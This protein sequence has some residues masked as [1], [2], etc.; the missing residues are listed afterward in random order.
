M[1]NVYNKRDKTQAVTSI[2]DY[3]KE[4]RKLLVTSGKS[5]LFFHQYSEKISIFQIRL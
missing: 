4:Q 2:T 1:Q 5:F 3:R